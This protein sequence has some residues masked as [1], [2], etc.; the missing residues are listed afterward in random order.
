MSRDLVIV[1]IAAAV[2]LG[3]FA[4]SAAA[5]FALRRRARRDPQLFTEERLRDRTLSRRLTTRAII[6]LAALPGGLVSGVLVTFIMFL[7]QREDPTLASFCLFLLPPAFWLLLSKLFTS[8]LTAA[9][10]AET[11]RRAAEE[12]ERFR[13]RQP[14]PKPGWPQPQPGQPKPAQLRPDQQQPEFI[15]AGSRSDSDTNGKYKF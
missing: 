15:A 11:W 6:R 8:T 7:Q 5:Y 14:Q 1:I 13:Q 3:C 9:A 10:T 4:V 2:V 12:G